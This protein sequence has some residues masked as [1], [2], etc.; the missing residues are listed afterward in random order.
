MDISKLA[1]VPMAAQGS[2]LEKIHLDEKSFHWLYNWNQMA[3]EKL[4][5]RIQKF[6]DC[7]VKLERVLKEQMFSAEN[8]GKH[9]PDLHCPRLGV[10][11][12]EAHGIMHFFSS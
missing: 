8:K 5:E 2:D 9:T 10:Q 3:M 12:C 11:Q 7:A 4:S 1:P 6:A